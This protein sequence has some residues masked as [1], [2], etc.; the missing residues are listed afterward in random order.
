MLLLHQD[1]TIESC[2]IAVIN[3]RTCYYC[4]LL[5]AIR[6]RR[7]HSRSSQ[8]KWMA[9][10]HVVVWRS[11]V[12]QNINTRSLEKCSSNGIRSKNILSIK[13]AFYLFI[14]YS[15]RSFEWFCHP[16]I[17]RIFNGNWNNFNIFIKSLTLHRIFHIDS[18]RGNSVGLI[19]TQYI[20]SVFCYYWILTIFQW[21]VSELF[22]NA[23]YLLC[24]WLRRTAWTS[25][26]AELNIGQHAMYIVCNWKAHVRHPKCNWFR[27]IYGFSALLSTKPYF[28][29][30]NGAH[31]VESI[32][33]LGVFTEH[34][35]YYYSFNAE[36]NELNKHTTGKLYCFAMYES[37]WDWLF[38]A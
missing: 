37:E 36:N 11:C 3:R 24:R 32:R 28:K 26:T 9:I 17:T 35:H 5:T 20:Y 30:R 6:S 8:S 27:N 22:G 34:Y 18:D 4:Y 23:P 14:E 10:G 7:S 31:T 25:N 29:W 13:V 33:A 21:I 1:A 12:K 16:S 38:V 15:H 19:F 2:E